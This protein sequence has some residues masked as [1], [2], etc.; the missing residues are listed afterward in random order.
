MLF[1]FDLDDTLY[2]CTGQMT[3][4][5]K[6]QDVLSI[7]LFPGVKELLSTLSARKILIT[8]ETD[9]G[10]Q[11]KKIETLGVR[12]FFDRIVICR[13]NEEKKEEFQ[14]IKQEFPEEEVWVIGD[15][16][17]AEVKY[18]NEL[19]WKTVHLCHGKHKSR[20]PQEKLEVPDFQITTFMELQQIL[21]KQ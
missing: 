2:D 18:A 6:W 17:D 7:S 15:R 5:N 3:E 10:L 8:K 1:I 12:S 13:S 19:G 11:D 20:T 4:Q 21:C 9:L 14:K 16:V